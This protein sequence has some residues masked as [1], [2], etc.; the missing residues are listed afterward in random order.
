MMKLW[1]GRF[2]KELT[3]ETERFT[4]SIE[5]DSRMI[6]H[7]I[8]GSEAHAIMLARQEIISQEDLRQILKWLEKAKGEYQ[9]GKFVL[10]RNLKTCI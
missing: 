2:S 8:W 3:S 1:G 10:N 9:K 6:L 7:D 4:E 5:I